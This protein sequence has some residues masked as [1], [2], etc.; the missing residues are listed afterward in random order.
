[1]NA[2][3]IAERRQLRLRVA[4]KVKYDAEPKRKIPV[5]P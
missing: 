3:D 5:N 2:E 4:M 1:M